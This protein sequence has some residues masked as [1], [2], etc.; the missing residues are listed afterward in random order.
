M[1][2]KFTISTRQSFRQ[3]LQIRLLRQPDISR[4]CCSLCCA[5]SLRYR[6]FQ[7]MQRLWGDKLSYPMH[8]TTQKCTFSSD[9]D[10]LKN[11]KIIKEWMA[12]IME[13]FER[14]E[15]IKARK[16]AVSAKSDSNPDDNNIDL[17][18]LEK[19]GFTVEEYLKMLRE[20][21]TLNTSDEAADEEMSSDS[22]SELDS[23]PS[24]S[25]TN[26]DKKA[27]SGDEIPGKDFSKIQSEDWSVVVLHDY[28]DGLETEDAVDEEMEVP[29]KLATKKASK[30]EQFDSSRETIQWSEMEIEDF[31]NLAPPETDV[32]ESWEPPV[33]LISMLL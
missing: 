2:V 24:Q 23:E 10:D 16:N 30:S 11:D 6:H 1:A 22:D 26:P 3:I 4:R 19:L 33:S 12:E 7:T 17:D 18:K 25:E 8:K 29:A 5:A 28:K 9:R 15:K 20:K 32:A 14:A 21:G 31:V 13:N 27:L